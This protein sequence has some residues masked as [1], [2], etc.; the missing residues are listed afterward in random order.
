MNAHDPTVLIPSLHDSI[1]DAAAGSAG[2]ADELAGDDDS[3]GRHF[4]D[5]PQFVLD[6]QQREAAHQ[7]GYVDASC[8]GCG[9]LLY[10]EVGARCGEVLCPACSRGDD[11]DPTPPG[12]A[13][14]VPPVDSPE[15]WRPTV[16]K[17]GDEQLV[18]AVDLADRDPHRL[19]LKTPAA[20]AAFVGVATAE[21]LRRLAA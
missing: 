16:R 1:S 13:V 9:C 5:D 2:F 6:M 20:R 17:L 21:V 15:F 12:A 14:T 3:T 18:T 10:V 19:G 8:G 7:L 4:A 11:T